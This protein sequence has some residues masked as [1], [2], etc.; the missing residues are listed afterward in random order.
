M[1][2]PLCDVEFAAYIGLDWADA[3]RYIRPQPS[4]TASF[5]NG[6]CPRPASH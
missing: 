2:H 6:S 5:A 3:K 4:D 1:K